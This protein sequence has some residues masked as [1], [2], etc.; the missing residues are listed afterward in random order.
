MGADCLN[1]GLRT[2]SRLLAVRTLL[3][4]PRVKREDFLLPT[5]GDKLRRFAAEVSEG[6]GFQVIRQN[7]WGAF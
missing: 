4:V 3:Q 7:Y 2:A 5:L 6:R 1:L